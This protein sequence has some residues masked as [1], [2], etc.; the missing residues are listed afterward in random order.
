M[1]DPR[2]ARRYA[3]P[4]QLP[5][6]RH[7]GATSGVVCAAP[8]AVGGAWPVGVSRRAKLVVSP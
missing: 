6:Q 4:A 8:G 7:A 3:Q 1:R 2:P 5:V